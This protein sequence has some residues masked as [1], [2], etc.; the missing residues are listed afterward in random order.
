M[1]GEIR[2]STGGISRV[3]Y[4]REQSPYSRY[5]IS[6]ITGLSINAL[7]SIEKNKDE[8]SPNFS[9]VAKLAKFFNVAI[10]EVYDVDLE[11]V[12]FDYEV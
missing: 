12:S 3:Q 8:Y 4:L 5:D 6:T 1:V 11:I 10:S 2:N 9:T 7:I